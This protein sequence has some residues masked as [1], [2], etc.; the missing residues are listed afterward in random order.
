M[1][2]HFFSKPQLEPTRMR[3]N[4]MKCARQFRDKRMNTDGTTNG[5]EN[6]V[7]LNSANLFFRISFD[8]PTR[9]HENSVSFKDSSPTLRAYVL[10]ERTTLVFMLQHKFIFCNDDIARRH[11]GVVQFVHDAD[12]Q[13]LHIS[14]LKLECKSLEAMCLRG[15]LFN[16]CNPTADATPTDNAQTAQPESIV[17]SILSPI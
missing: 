3:W 1:I 11:Q 14:V 13:T 7:C 6:G 5:S 4:I 17:R 9:E 2:R 16:S 8:D 10:N 15:S 12:L